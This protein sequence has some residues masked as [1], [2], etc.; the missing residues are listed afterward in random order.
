MWDF[1]KSDRG[2]CTDIFINTKKLI[3]KQLV[4]FAGEDE[5]VL[6]K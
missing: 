4:L 6:L 1:N 2:L 3:I 5:L